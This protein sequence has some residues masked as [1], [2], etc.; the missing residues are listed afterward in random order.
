MLV[1]EEKDSALIPDRRWACVRGRAF[2]YVFL[3]CRVVEQPIPFFIIFTAEWEVV[4]EA[5]AYL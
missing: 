3:G 1:T 5:F 2:P 4:V